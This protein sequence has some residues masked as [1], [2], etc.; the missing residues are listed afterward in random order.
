MDDNGEVWLNTR[1]AAARLGLPARELY[2]LI[3]EGDLV[4]YKDERDLL[5]RPG[6]IEAYQSARS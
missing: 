5:L 2:R 4:A 3:D 6:D 1:Q